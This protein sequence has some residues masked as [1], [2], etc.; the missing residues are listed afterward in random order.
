MKRQERGFARGRM[1]R[2]ADARTHRWDLRK[3]FSVSEVRDVG[4]LGDG[5]KEPDE[6]GAG[7]NAIARK[8]K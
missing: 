1:E 2:R 4:A 8:S 6:F 7:G 5:G 3:M